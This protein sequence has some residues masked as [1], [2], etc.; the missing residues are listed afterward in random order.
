M[1]SPTNLGPRLQALFDLVVHAQAD[2]TYERIWDCCCDHG[3]LGIRIVAEQLC[4]ELIFVD[5]IDKIMQQLQERLDFLSLRNYCTLTADVNQLQFSSKQR[6]LVILAGVGGENIVTMMRTIA[7]NNPDSQID[8]LLC[9]A[10]T[11]FNL[12]HYL[13]SQHF[14]LE[15]EAFICEKNRHYEIIYVTACADAARVKVSLTGAMWQADNRD[16]HNYLNKLKRHYQHKSRDQRD[17]ES[18]GI[19]KNYADC[20]KN[21]SSSSVI[22]PQK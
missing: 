17:S 12:R 7:R 14:S 11:Q 8:Y 5:Q 9:P 2:S 1:S 6:H 15:H 22:S 21:M 19:F 20:L 13:A 18:Y 10:T 4:D 16:H 3:F